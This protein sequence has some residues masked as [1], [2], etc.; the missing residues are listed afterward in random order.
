LKTYIR[1]LLYARPLGKYIFPFVL[2]SIVSS[3]FGVLNF[4][5]LQPLLDVLFDKVTLSDVSPESLKRPAFDVIDI[6]RWFNYYFG[7][8]MREHGKMGALK[9]VCAAIVGSVL[10]AN[11]SKYF[12]VRVIET[13]KAR[14]VA[15]LRQ[16]VF[17]KTL[18]LHLGFF[19]NERKGDLMARITTDVQ[20]IESSIGKV[21]SAVF[22]E[23]FTLL[24][25]VLTLFS[26]SVQLTFF[27]LVILPIS[28][29]FIGVLAKKLKEKALDVQE[30]LANVISILDESF[31]VSE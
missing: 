11:V 20:E 23:I 25:Y 10:I 19:S 2:F 7:V 12:A 9:Y 8:M 21:F 5:L 30:R 1:V 29:I 22:K 15:N 18:G 6:T 3:V 13:F 24:F 31:G 4:S 16:A 27:S 14:T 26:M 17:D 28:G